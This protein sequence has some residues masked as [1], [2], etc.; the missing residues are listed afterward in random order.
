MRPGCS[1]I[2]GSEPLTDST[3]AVQPNIIYARGIPD[4]LLFFNILTCHLLI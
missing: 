2:Y 3:P 1:Y 4:P